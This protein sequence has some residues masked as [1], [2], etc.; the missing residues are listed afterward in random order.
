MGIVAV[1]RIQQ[2]HFGLE[3]VHDMHHLSYA[4]LVADFMSGINQVKDPVVGNKDRGG[5]VQN[6]LDVVHSKANDAPILKVGQSLKD[7]NH[8]GVDREE[9]YV[10]VELLS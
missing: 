10:A 6:G 5:L 3:G 4:G 9:V 8:V 2:V 1:A 7:I